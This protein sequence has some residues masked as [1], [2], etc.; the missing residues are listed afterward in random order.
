MINIVK[1]APQNVAAF[2]AEGEVTQEDF[3]NVVLPH[4]KEI[5]EKTGEL[6]YLLKLDTS[7]AN[8]TA[9]AW[10]KDA[11]LGLKNLSKWNRVAIVTDKSSIQTFTDI[12]SVVMPGKFIG[13]D[14]IDYQTA[15]HWVATG[16]KI[17][18]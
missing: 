17:E 13:F 2:V 16:E 5:T 3:D 15:L 10:L 7:I 18:G 4:V 9:G 14:K 6:N 1:D 11:L 12:F 8:F